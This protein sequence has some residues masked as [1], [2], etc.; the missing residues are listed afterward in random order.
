M[1]E[2]QKCNK[3]RKGY[4]K[5]TDDPIESKCDICGWSVLE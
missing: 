1:M 2:Q 5:K 4:L 3:C